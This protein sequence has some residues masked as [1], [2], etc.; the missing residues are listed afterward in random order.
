MHSK[1]RKKFKGEIV[2]DEKNIVE[3]ML[4]NIFM[5]WWPDLSHGLFEAVDEG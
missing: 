2:N 1:K 3:P 4:A 5:I